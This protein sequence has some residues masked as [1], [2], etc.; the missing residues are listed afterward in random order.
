MAGNIEGLAA[1]ILKKYGADHPFTECMQADELAGYDEETR[2]AICGRVKALSPASSKTKATEPFEV[3]VFATGNWLGRPWT[4]AHLDEMVANFGR[5]KDFVK[6][7]VKLGHN[8]EQILAQQDGQPALGWVA[9]LRRV[10]TKLLATIRDMPELIKDLVRARRYDRVSAELYPHW[11]D[12]SAEQSLGTGVT[13]MVMSALALLGADVPEVKTLDD[14]HRV[15]ASEIGGDKLTVQIVPATDALCV[16]TEP[17]RRKSRSNAWSDRYRDP[18]FP[19]L[20]HASPASRSLLADYV[21]TQVAAAITE[22]STTA[23][24]PRPISGVSEPADLAEGDVNKDGTFV[25][26]FQGCVDHMMNTKGLDKS[27]AEALC[28]YIGRQAGKI[29]GKEPE[30]DEAAVKKL[31][32]DAST[33][34]AETVRAQVVAEMAEVQKGKDAEIVKLREQNDRL[35]ARH[36]AAEARARAGDAREEIARRSTADN[37]RLFPV[38][39]TAARLLWERLGTD[40]LF[41]AAEATERGAF[42]EKETQRDLTGRELLRQLLDGYPP[43]NSLWREQGRVEPEHAEPTA[44]TFADE[45]AKRIGAD[46]SKTEERIRVMT[47]VA[48]EH[49]EVVPAYGRAAYQS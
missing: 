3:E 20:T 22:L 13:G 41:T 44:L 5:L 11:E 2:R 4:T 36:E 28:A 37:Y 15:L 9:S 7:P 34:T 18:F 25:G 47:I 14:L 38:Q 39:Q 10:G 30:M 49:P 40:V 32:E 46:M 43:Q 12:T 48:R 8:D 26:G 16:S 1:H 6:P 45:V 17:S 27:H 33:K 19:S 23:T 42:G 24:F 21:A 29:P 35:A 31:I